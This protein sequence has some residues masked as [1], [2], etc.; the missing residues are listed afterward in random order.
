MGGLAAAELQRAT[1]EPARNQ[2]DGQEITRQVEHVLQIV[3][4]ADVAQH[5]LQYLRAVGAGE[6]EGAANPD[7]EIPIFAQRREH[8]SLL[9]QGFDHQMVGF[10]AELLKQVTARFGVAPQGFVADVYRGMRPRA[11][12][13]VLDTFT[14]P[15]IALHQHHVGLADVAL[16]PD[17]VVG[18]PEVVLLKRLGQQAQG[19]PDQAAPEVVQ[20]IDSQCHRDSERR[21]LHS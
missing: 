11:L 6:V 17:Q 20:P 5:L 2:A 14:D 16:E 12:S 8:H 3:S 19:E 9:D 13:Q 10:L 15:L 21:N 1:P 4:V 7:V 18:N